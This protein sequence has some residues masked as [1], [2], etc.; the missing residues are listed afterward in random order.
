M[1][2][3]F[4]NILGAEKGP[5]DKPP[6]PK[7]A[8]GDRIYAVGDIHGRA[9]LLYKMIDLIVADVERQDDDREAR[10]LFLGDYVDRGDNSQD[11]VSALML[12]EEQLAFEGVDFLMGNHESALLAFLDDP[13][14]RSEWL[15]FG[16]LQTLGSYNVA[17]PKLRGDAGE[18]ISISDALSDEMGTHVA[19]LRSCKFQ[20]RS[21]DVIFTH[22]GVEPETDLE[23]QT[24]DA[25][26][27]G[28]STFLE[29][30]LPPHLRFVHGHFD[31]IDPVLT[32]NRIC[33]DTGA[34]Y[35]GILTAVRLDQGCELLAVNA[36]D[37]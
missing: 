2:R 11:V 18:L 9:D 3:L 13:T 23:K 29:S 22:A 28:R 5:K 8:D 25:L 14:G 12:I 24:E 27:W 17:P 35:T 21:G 20:H 32:T 10:L 31:D 6:V 33:V 16:G 37:P 15:R 30:P 4:R 36:L 34:Y 1:V 26:L 19:F 7:V